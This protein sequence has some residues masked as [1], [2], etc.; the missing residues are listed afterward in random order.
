MSDIIPSSHRPGAA[1]FK[2]ASH[3]P[4]TGC[5]NRVDSQH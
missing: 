5:E 4:I 1:I 2:M 3:E